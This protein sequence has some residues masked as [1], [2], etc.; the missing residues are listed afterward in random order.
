MPT[1]YLEAAVKKAE[2][3]RLEEIGFTAREISH[4]IYSRDS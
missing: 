4:E 3:K 2:Y 1:K